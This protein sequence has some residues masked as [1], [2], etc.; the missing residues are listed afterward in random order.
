MNSKYRMTK[1]GLRDLNYY[2]PKP[3]KAGAVARP[4]ADEGESAVVPPVPP[5][6][7]E[8]TPEAPAAG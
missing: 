8:P 3:A 4:A 1:Q 7:P 2:G 5:D 6:S